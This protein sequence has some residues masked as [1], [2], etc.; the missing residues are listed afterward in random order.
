MLTL[1]SIPETKN[2]E[3]TS[4]RGWG[5][6][7]SFRSG[8]GTRSPMSST[9][10]CPRTLLLSWCWPSPRPSSC[11]VLL[12]SRDP[13]RQAS[14]RRVSTE[15]DTG[16]SGEGHSSS[17]TEDCQDCLSRPGW[18]SLA[19]IL[20]R[21]IWREYLWLKDQVKMFSSCIFFLGE[22]KALHFLLSNPKC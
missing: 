12:M 1:A 2:S 11:P 9:T 6:F 21:T 17:T 7:L 5:T 3:K 8:S 10:R 4:L 15:T 22:P 14:A 16:D 20:I 19:M 13:C 18:V